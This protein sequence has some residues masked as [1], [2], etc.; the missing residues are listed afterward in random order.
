MAHKTT[1][2]TGNRQ[3]SSSTQWMEY[4]GFAWCEI[5]LQNVRVQSLHTFIHRMAVEKLVEDK[6]DLLAAIAAKESGFDQSLQFNEVRHRL[7]ELRKYIL[8]LPRLKE[9]VELASF[10]KAAF[11]QELTASCKAYYRL[12][13]KAN[14]EHVNELIDELFVYDVKS[15][16]Q[17]KL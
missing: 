11:R 10:F 2:D 3:T 1:N 16:K 17:I 13:R 4:K 14:Q 12:C 7:I 5:K 9:D 8:N 15:N 6:L